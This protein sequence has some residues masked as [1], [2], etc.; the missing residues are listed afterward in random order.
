MNMKTAEE[1]YREALERIG[2]VIGRPLTCYAGVERQFKELSAIRDE[3]FQ[4]IRESLV[5][6]Y[7]DRSTAWVPSVVYPGY[8]TR[9]NETGHR[10]LRSK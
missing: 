8:E 5:S 6:K 7:P 9:L 3:V 10:E 1:Q 2:N 4:I